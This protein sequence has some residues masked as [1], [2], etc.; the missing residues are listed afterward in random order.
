M[1]AEKA[2]DSIE[3]RLS[4]LQGALANGSA[5]ETVIPTTD[6]KGKGKARLVEVDA[7]SKL[8]KT[9]IEGEIKELLDLK[10][11]LALKVK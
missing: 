6:V 4:D 8:S 1:H 5:P 10:E 7:V 11:D 3:C 9:Q 2:L